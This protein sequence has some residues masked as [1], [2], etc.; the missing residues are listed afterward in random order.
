MARAAAD[1]PLETERLVL[2]RFR[3][4]DVDAFIGYRN[5]PEVARFQSWERLSTRDAGRILREQATLKPGTRGRWLQIA[6]ET[7]DTGALVGDCALRVM[8]D[9][10]WQAEIGFTLARDHQGHGYATEAVARLLDFALVTLDLHRV[11]AITVKENVRSIALLE[12]L[13]MRREAV[14][15]E[16]VWF[17]GRWASE[18]LYAMLAADWRRARDGTVR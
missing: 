6:I 2:R 13:G 12:R 3:R 14:F 7:R 11:V 9:E 17:K 8:R 18:Y 16:N 5:D 15:E 4:D 1:L 10:P